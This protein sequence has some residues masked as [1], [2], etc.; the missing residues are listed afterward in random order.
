MASLGSSFKIEESKK[1]SYRQK[2]SNLCTFKNAK[3]CASLEKSSTQT[4]LRFQW[5][6]VKNFLFPGP[7]L[8]S[9]SQ[10]CILML[11]K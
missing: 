7:G 6:T 4:I 2:I 1:A 5:H 9:I 8:V 11:I 3:I 10:D